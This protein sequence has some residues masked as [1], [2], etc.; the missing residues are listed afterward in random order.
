MAGKMTTKQRRAMA[1][2]LDGATNKQAAAAAGVSLRTI[3]R[4][5]ADD[6]FADELRRRSLD[7]VGDAAMRL[8]GTV[9]HAIDRLRAILDND[10]ARPTDHLRAA[11]LVI[12]A[13]T[14]LTETEEILERVEALERRMARRR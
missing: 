6:G 14:R 10:A 2:L 11:Q 4:Y 13:A 12:D 5:R 9:A 7:M 8:R 3:Q 1:A